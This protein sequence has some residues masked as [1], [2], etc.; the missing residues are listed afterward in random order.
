MVT[1]RNLRAKAA[2]AKK[3]VCMK[4]TTRGEAD[5]AAMP[6]RVLHLMT[7]L[8]E[9]SFIKG[10]C[11][12]A[13]QRLRAS[14][15]P[16]TTTSTNQ[17]SKA[18]LEKVTIDVPSVFDPPSPYQ[19]RVD[20]LEAVKQDHPTLAW[21]E[22][23]RRCVRVQKPRSSPPLLTKRSPKAKRMGRPPKKTEKELRKHVMRKE[24]DQ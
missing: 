15:T 20:E 2:N 18:V 23:R 16:A 6:V 3:A 11:I 8:T 7:T 19:P 4:A 13:S 14:P 9:K 17:R 1:T 21:R 12:R 24:R 22:T 10:R 5:A